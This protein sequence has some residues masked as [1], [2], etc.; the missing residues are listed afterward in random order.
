MA[1]KGVF[2]KM[3]GLSDKD[4]MTGLGMQ[5]MR[6]D[7]LARVI[8]HNARVLILVVALAVVEAVAVVWLLLTR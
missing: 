2:R 8:N 5:A 3:H 6:A 4:L 7:M 1:T